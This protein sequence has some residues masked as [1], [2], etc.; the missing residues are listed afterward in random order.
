M[1]LMGKVMKDSDKTYIILAVSSVDIS[2]TPL[3]L[4]IPTL[5]TSGG[6]RIPS[7]GYKEQYLPAYSP[8]DIAVCGL[9][10]LYNREQSVTSLNDWFV[11]N[12]NPIAEA[13]V[14]CTI[15]ELYK[16]RIN[17]QT[18]SIADWKRVSKGIHQLEELLKKNA[19][20]TF[21]TIS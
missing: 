2:R 1:T 11:A 8:I 21:R 15:A 10:A 6:Y 20:F 4:D 18:L 12:P 7:E 14:T 3:V 9:T 17:I 19:P 16:I 13:W 5:G